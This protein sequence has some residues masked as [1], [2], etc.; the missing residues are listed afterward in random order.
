MFAL[1]RFLL[2]VIFSDLKKY[3]LCLLHRSIFILRCYSLFFMSSDSFTK[4]NILPLRKVRNSS[5]KETYPC[6]DEMR[7]NLWPLFFMWFDEKNSKL[8]KLFI[9]YRWIYTAHFLSGVKFQ[10]PQ[11]S[12]SFIPRLVRPSLGTSVPRTLSNRMIMWKITW[13]L[14]ISWNRW[15]TLW[16]NFEGKQEANMK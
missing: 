7:D 15:L 16:W 13:N 10:P 11:S 6:F 9:F 5:S 4:I 2:A 12:H 3:G 1:F 14:S 8:P